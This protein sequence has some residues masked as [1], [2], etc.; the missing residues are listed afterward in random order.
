M[1]LTDPATEPAA[2]Q[3]IAAQLK[4]DQ[5]VWLQDDGLRVIWKQDA[6]DAV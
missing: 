4:P 3:F 2:G 5:F 1:Y 6:E